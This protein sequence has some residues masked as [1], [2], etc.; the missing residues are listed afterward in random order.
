MAYAK[1]NYHIQADL[2][3][4]AYIDE[5]NSKIKTADG[6][7][8]RVPNLTVGQS[9]RLVLECF[10][11]HDDSTEA[12][13]RSNFDGATASLKIKRRNST[14]PGTV[15]DSAVA[16]ATDGT[17]SEYNTF[18]FDVVKDL[19]TDY[20]DGKE[21]TLEVTITEGS[22][23]K[24]TL[25]QN[26]EVIS[27]DGTGDNDI[28]GGD[29]EA[30]SYQVVAVTAAPDAN[31]DTADG[32]RVGDYVWHTTGSQLYR[33]DGADAGAAIWTAVSAVDAWPG[34]IQYLVNTTAGDLTLALPSL[35]VYAYQHLTVSKTTASNTATISG[36]VNGTSN[37]ALY[38]T[39]AIDLF[40]H[41]ATWYQPHYDK[42]I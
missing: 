2:S 38:G 19:I 26:L 8:P 25:L 31:L 5:D 32:Y 6:Y 37:P 27:A 24:T 39:Q 16:V 17:N 20:Y 9:F 12:A 40:S 28:D 30:S 34:Q 1:N 23:H 35:A 22:D 11:D 29:I 42:F 36:T 18:T 7:E 10:D 4:S 41:A 15:L 14:E 3:R 13:R 21:C 33:C